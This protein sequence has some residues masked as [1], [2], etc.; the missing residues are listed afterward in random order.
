MSRDLSALFDPASVAVV[1]ASDDPA[2]WGNWLARGALAGRSR[3]TVHLVNRRA[4]TVLGEKAYTSLAQIGAPVELVV[5][6]VPAAAFAS[7]VH[8][9]LE[10][11]ARAIV[12]ISA[13]LGEAGE[14]GARLQRE[15]QA[16]VRAADAVLLGPNCLGVMDS[17]AELHLVSNP[18]PAGRVALLSQSGNLSLELGRMLQWHG[19]GFSRFASLGNQ[20]DL[21]VADLLVACAEHKG[22]DAIAV[23]CEDFRDGRRF[24]AAARRAGE[25]GKPVVL[26]TVGSSEAS[27][28]GARSHTGSLVSGSSVV[29]AACAAGGVL[30][31]ATPAQLAD[32]LAALLSGVRPDGHAGRRLAVL[33]DGGGHASIAADV[34]EVAGLRVPELSSAVMAELAAELPPTAATA[35]PIDVAGGGEQDITCFSR[36]TRGLLGSG[37]VDAVLLTGYFGGYGEYSPELAEREVEVAD[38][39]ARAAREAGRPLVVH[40]MYPDTPA[41]AALR[42]GRVPVYR[43]VEAAVGA[44]AR[45]MA[46]PPAVPAPLPIP[47]PA[48]PV[49]EDDYWSSRALLAEAGVPFPAAVLVYDEAGLTAAPGFPCVLKAVGLLHKSDAGGVSLG[50]PDAASLTAAYRD[51]Q[52]RLGP[53]PC[54]VEQMADVSGGVELIAGVRRDPRFGPVAMVG[55]GGV[56]TEILADVACALAPLRADEAERLLA[57]LRGAALLRGARGRTPVDVA[58]AARVIAAITELAAAHPEIAELEVNPLLV[59]PRGALAL[60]ARIV[61]S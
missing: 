39:L 35:N 28:R 48:E 13:G 29:D 55:L 9:A 37:E 31:V 23:Y 20:A 57:G 42:S 17:A 38:A 50:I 56:Y 5:V 1:G 40:S 32:L 2:K 6:A 12:G 51:L 19:H 43:T 52:D 8:E 25:T 7:A 3:R 18:M 34:A 22:T 24:V 36:V 60:D 30:R 10:A 16:D 27:R 46:A 14:D 11:G 41:A 26:L 4:G 33:S 44:L 45:V 58:A 59:T 15:L 61:L 54:T 47:V 49:S 21:D 53:L